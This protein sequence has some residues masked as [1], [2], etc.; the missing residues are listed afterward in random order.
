MRLMQKEK[1]VDHQKIFIHW[2]DCFVESCV[3]PYS[4]RDS[5]AVESRY[6]YNPKNDP[7]L[8]DQILDFYH[9]EKN[10]RD[11]VIEARFL[12]R[13][14][15]F[16]LGGSV[17]QIY[18]DPLL[19]SQEHFFLQKLE[20]TS[21]VIEKA[22]ALGSSLLEVEFDP[23]NLSP[24]DEMKLSLE[25]L[26]SKGARRVVIHGETAPATLDSF[27][28]IKGLCADLGLE[29][30]PR[31]AQELGAERSFKNLIDACI[32]GRL[33][34]F[35]EHMSQRLSLKKNV[36]S[37]YYVTRWGLKKFDEILPSDLIG[38]AESY[39]EKILSENKIDFILD[40]GLEKIVLING[41]HRNDLSSSA[42]SLASLI[43]GRENLIT[44]LLNPVELDHNQEASMGEDPLSFE[45]GPMFLGRGQKLTVLD[46]F[47]HRAVSE[48]QAP[49]DNQDIENI[50]LS[51]DCNS[52]YRR[53]EITLKTLA[54][55]SN[56][57]SRT[58]SEFRDCILQQFIEGLLSELSLH[59]PASAQ[60]IVIGPMA[61]LIFPQN[62]A[63]KVESRRFTL[64]L[65]KRNLK[66]LVA[67][68]L[69]SC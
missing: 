24:Q 69:V 35:N 28:K 1:P 13:Y 38:A 25:S 45:P 49:F 42:L 14:F 64:P 16:S 32:F 23:D 8:L 22:P 47:L 55:N 17:A 19:K 56:N 53:I 44:Q 15:S 48:Q 18:L 65:E 67:Q 41:A 58:A 26:K 57:S 59:V 63:R 43:P 33:S 66:L 11:I 37:L 39:Y 2:G 31:T 12:E 46:C 62:Q 34:E 60:G 51:K 9:D 3:C 61:S 36:S 5:S 30:F 50:F 68:E 29:T 27:Q 52:K 10:P 7:K 54:K 21:S 20:P 6:F 4:K 40:M